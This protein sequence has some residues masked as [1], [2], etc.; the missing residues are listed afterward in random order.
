[1]LFKLSTYS[2]QTVI[3]YLSFLLTQHKQPYVI[4]AFYLLNTNSHML[5]KFPT[6]STQRVICYLS[7]LLTQHKQPYAI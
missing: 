7:F 5:F 1:M 2:T 6:Y 3:C 4:Q